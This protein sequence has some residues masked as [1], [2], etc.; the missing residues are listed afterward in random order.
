M[1]A[2]RQ[3]RVGVV[4]IGGGAPVSLQSMTKTDTRDAE[5]TIAQIQELETA[6][7][8]LVR[9]AIP[10][11]EAAQA[12]ADIRREVSLP[13]IADIHFDH[14][15]A[16]AALEA[17]ADKLRLNPGN[18]RKPEH[19]REVV[20]AAQERRV[21]IR[22]GANLGSLPPDVRSK[23]GDSL[24]SAHDAA[25]ALFEAALHHVRILEALDFRD[26]VLSLKAFDVPATIKAYRIAAAET[27]YPLHVGITEAGP[28]PG[29]VVRSAVGIGALLAEGIG[30]TIRVSLSAPPVEEVR[31]GREILRSLELRH[32]G[33]TL[34]SCPTCSRCQMDVQQVALEVERELR[35]LDDRLRREGR[36]VRVA[37][38]GCAVNGPGEARDADVGIAAD[39]KGAILFSKGKVARRLAPEEA[40]PALTA[41]ARRLADEVT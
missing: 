2:S 19:I 23:Y 9:V 8:D 12:F 14:R 25:R 10:D 39:A 7:C 5:A 6:G 17:G 24:H 27:D 37:V 15:L 41:E 35:A 29:G 21:P 1:R 26:I 34:V 4:L 3:V 22:I 36:D 31:V 20:A 33:I 16:L 38:M 18:I 32:G 30:D 40:V 13:L 28:P 11:A